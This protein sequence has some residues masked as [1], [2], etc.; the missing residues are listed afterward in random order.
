MQ[1]TYYYLLIDEI[2]GRRVAK[3]MGILTIGLIGVLIKAKDLKIIKNVKVILNQLRTKANFYL[4]NDL[5]I[6]ILKTVNNS[7]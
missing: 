3:E 2:V 6:E 7:N 1:T 4:S 5:Y